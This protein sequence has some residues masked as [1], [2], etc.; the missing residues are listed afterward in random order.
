MGTREGTDFER[1][2]EAAL[3]G[4]PERH[5]TKT[6]EQGKLPVRERVERLVDAG[7]V[8]RGGPARQLGRRGPRRRRRR[9]RPRA[10]RRA[11]GL[12]DGQRPD[13]E[14]R[15]LGP[16]DGREDPPDPG[17]GADAR[18]ADDLPGRL[19]RGA[20]HRPGADVPRP[21]RRRAD[22]LQRGQ[23]LRPRAAGL[24]AVR[25]LGRRR[26]LHPGLLRRRDHA[27]GQRLDVPGLA[28]DGRDGDRREG[29]PG[30]DGRGED[31]HR[32][33]GLRPLPGQDRR[34]GDRARPA[35][36]L[37]HAGELARAPAGGAA[38]RARGRPGGLADRARRREDLVRHQG[39]DRRP[40]RRRLV[41]RGA[42][43]LGEGAGRRL[44]A[45][46]RPRD[47]DRR[48][49]A[50][51]TRAASC[52]STRPTRRRASSSPAT[53]STSRCSSSPTCPGS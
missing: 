32:C 45:A 15:L 33:L 34:G 22:L 4:G 21:P 24:P 9:H 44:R 35:L 40:G 25:P 14:G 8:Q 27:R 37:V 11:Q 19:G 38:G 28:A 23:A 17:A 51:S 31:A 13:R 43:A 7:V 5:H 12:P 30:G 36:P 3:A 50:A 26:R 39:A 53:P 2:L 20:D 46:R 42:R 10:D 48:Q 49:P 41:L 18:A 52:S 6:A 29:E 16:E 47:R 1:A